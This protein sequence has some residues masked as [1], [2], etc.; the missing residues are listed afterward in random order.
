MKRELNFENFYVYDGNKVTYLAAKKVVEFPGE[1]FNPLYVYGESGLGKTHLL[2]A[3]YYELNKKFTTLF[4]SAKEFEKFL[5]ITT[6]FDTSMII[7]DLH[8]VS[9]KYYETILGIIDSFLTSNKQICFSG[10]V[11]PRDFKNFDARLISRLEGGLVC[12][13]IPSKE[14]ELVDLIKKKSGESG[15]LLPDEIALELAQIS[16]GSVRAIEGMINRLIAYS[17]LGSLSFETDS[18]RMILKE[19][20]PKGI[21]SPVSSLLEEL[22]KNAS[23]IL[24]DVSEKLD[25][26]EEYKEKIY[27]WEMKGFDT[28]SLKLLIE[29]DIDL[30]RKE[31][32]NFIKKIEKL[33]ALQKEFGALDTGDFPDEAMKI[34]S[35]I[36][37]PEHVDDIEKLLTKIKKT[38]KISVFEKSF[39]KFIVGACNKNACDIYT[40]KI[41]KNLG[42]KFNP[43]IIFGGKGTGK[44]RFLEAIYSDLIAQNKSVKFYDFAVKDEILESDDTEKYDVFLF[45][46]FHHAFSAPDDLRKKIFNSIQNYI[47]VG[48]AVIFSSAVSSSDLLL[49]DNEKSILE[50]GIEAELET[51][52]SEV[53]EAHIK[54]KLELNKAEKILN[55]GVP[56]F[57]SFYEIDEFLYSTKTEELVKKIPL[58]PSEEELAK[59]VSL[60][61]LGEESGQEEKAQEKEEIKETVISKEEEIVA[62]EKEEIKEEKL[63]TDKSRLL[64]DIKEE[65]FI[66]QEISG[67]LIEDNY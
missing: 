7:D 25:I 39:D 6:I 18:V 49:S 24:Q 50:F 38:H 20:Y 48:K 47:K 51:P 12:D 36:F 33:I 21:H 22:K 19:F 56:K 8:I 55:K 13:I 67:E 58:E 9:N 52:S 27:I 16:N 31:Y 5:D 26:R 61:L 65:R 63:T 66:I 4:F 44:T 30:L 46:N 2:L 28:S 10:N 64:K 35:M 15:I 14:I 60:G 17:S 53:V 59:V 40:E 3:I 37:S 57:S 62:L 54:S 29:G 23:E 32:D 45:D 41:L 43:F 34:E 1:I 11:A 42:K